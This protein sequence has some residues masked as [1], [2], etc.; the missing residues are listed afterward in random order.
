MLLKYAKLSIMSLLIGCGGA[1]KR[2][3]EKKMLF[4]YFLPESRFNSLPEL[5]KR[6]IIVLCLLP[7]DTNITFF[8]YLFVLLDNT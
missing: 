6:S 5:R 8:E 7:N 4:L 3:I 2:Q 1:V